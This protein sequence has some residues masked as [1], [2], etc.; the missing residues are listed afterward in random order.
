MVDRPLAR[1]Q[2]HHAGRPDPARRRRRPRLFR[3]RLRRRRSALHRRRTRSG[4]DARDGP[5]TTSTAGPPSC[6]RRAWRCRS[7]TP[8]WTSAC[9]PTSPSTCRSRGGWARDAAG[10]QARRPGG[11]VVHGVA[12]PVRRPRDGPDPLPR[13]RPRRRALHPQARPS[14]R[15][16]TT[17]R[18][19]SRCR[20]RTGWTGRRAPA[21]WSPHF[22]ATTR[23]GRGG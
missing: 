7:P 13:R 12:R 18:R 3:G 4:R 8:A 22:P 16:T 6:G 21:R 19:C 1:R 23:D 10:H 17:D 15:R 20:R 9:R 14:G 5:A 2:R 11:A